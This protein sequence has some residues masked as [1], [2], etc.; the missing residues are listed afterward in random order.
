MLKGLLQLLGLNS[1]GKSSAGEFAKDIRE[2]LKGKEIDPNR[3]LDLIEVQT[4]LNET[5][6]QHRTVFVA[7]WRPF[8]G[9][10]LGF[11]LGVYYIPQFAMASYLW[12]KMCMEA[13]S[14]LDYPKLNVD[15]LFELVLGMLGLAAIRT[16]EKVKGKTK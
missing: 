11:S 12:V 7:G 15:S 8:I 14:L 1:E 4:K 9:W 5:E 2:A 16:Y 10:I 13:N 6:A 3:A